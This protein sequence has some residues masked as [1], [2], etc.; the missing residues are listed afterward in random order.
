MTSNKIFDNYISHI[1]VF[2]LCSLDN[3]LN[4][5][6]AATSFYGNLNLP[7]LLVFFGKSCFELYMKIQLLIND[8]RGFKLSP[9]KGVSFYIEDDNTKI[10]MDCGSEWSENLTLNNITYIVLSHGH[11]DHSGG[12]KHVNINQDALEK[13]TLI[14]HP[15][16]LEKRY[17]INPL[18]TRSD[19]RLSLE[20][21]KTKFDIKLTTEAIWL[22]KKMV[23]L[24]DVGGCKLPTGIIKTDN[25][26]RLDY[27]NDDSSLVYCSEKGLVIITGCNHAGL[28]KHINKAIRIT[29]DKRVYAIVGG[30]HFNGLSVLKLPFVLRILKKTNTTNFYTC[31]C[32]GKI[33]EKILNS[34]KMST[35]DILEFI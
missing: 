3:V 28:K 30:L 25:K 26:I 18:K 34:K 12:I 15:D 35:G 6:R 24:G 31:H 17:A 33:A 1:G 23:F 27:I 5:Y 4:G 29:G 9:N 13:I 7:C 11:Y 32:T 19:G 21:L 22:T 10:L 16:A 20:K 8:I 14:A 2:P